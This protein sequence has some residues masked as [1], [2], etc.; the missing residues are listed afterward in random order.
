M[1]LFDTKRVALI[2][3]ADFACSKGEE[4]GYSL[5]FSEPAADSKENEQLLAIGAFSGQ[6]VWVFGTTARAPADGKAKKDSDM[7]GA[8]WTSAGLVYAPQEEARK[9]T[10]T[11]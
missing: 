9:A 10:T 3:G 2:R 1:P 7:P 6:R 5:A 11:S 8:L 4:F